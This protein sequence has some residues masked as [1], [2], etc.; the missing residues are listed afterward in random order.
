M[1]SL[2]AGAIAAHDAAYYAKRD[3]RRVML[4]GDAILQVFDLQGEPA[5]RNLLKN[6]AVKCTNLR[7]SIGNQL[8]H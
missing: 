7:G 8:K 1:E 5:V 2:G 6:W 4:G 3:H